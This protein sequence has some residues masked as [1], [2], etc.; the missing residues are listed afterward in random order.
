MS[1]MIDL[2]QQYLIKFGIEITLIKCIFEK[3]L[4]ISNSR[5]NCLC[6]IA[7]IQLGYNIE[8]FESNNNIS[9]KIDYSTLLYEMLLLTDKNYKCLND[10]DL[11]L[12]LCIIKNKQNLIYFILNSRSYFE[13]ILMLLLGVNNLINNGE[14][15]DSQLLVKYL[16]ILKKNYN[17]NYIDEIKSKVS[18]FVVSQLMFAI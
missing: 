9:E 1:L 15:L 14:I 16:R 11:I 13:S 7:F 4:D 3:E 12:N 5:I 18:S 2:L 10:H 8:K 17:I 6:K